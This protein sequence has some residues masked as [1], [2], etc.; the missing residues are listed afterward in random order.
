M[1]VSD[2]S[3]DA[4]LRSH[5]ARGRHS[6]CV[7]PVARSAPSRPTDGRVRSGAFALPGFSPVPFSPVH[8]ATAAG[9]ATAFFRRQTCFPLLRGAPVPSPG[10]RCVPGPGGLHRE[11][12]GTVARL[13]EA[14]RPAEIRRS[15]LTPD[16]A[17]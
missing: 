16:A 8:S 15:A 12:A 11:G 9:R 7:V 4:Y 6:Y 2:L 13:G 1:V 17:V 10:H 14:T 5:G 3:P